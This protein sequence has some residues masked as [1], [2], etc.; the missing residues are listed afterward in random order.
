MQS[1]PFWLHRFKFNFFP[2]ANNSDL[3]GKL[4]TWVTWQQPFEAI[5]NHGQEENHNFFRNVLTAMITNGRNEGVLCLSL[6]T[7]LPKGVYSI[8]LCKCSFGTSETYWIYFNAWN[9][10]EGLYQSSWLAILLFYYIESV[11]SHLV[12]WSPP[13]SNVLIFYCCCNKLPQTWKTQIYYLTGL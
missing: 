5:P 10:I 7:I 2:A 9:K 1:C 3:I 12:P 8:A 13:W 11:A 4:Y 6:L